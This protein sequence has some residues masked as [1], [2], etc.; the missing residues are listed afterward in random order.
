M[1]VQLYGFELAHERRQ[2]HAG[3]QTE[4]EAVCTRV[5]SANRTL[6]AYTELDYAG[7]S[8]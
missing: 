7:L 1:Q 5:E 4:R 3:V 8:A 6:Q 2:G